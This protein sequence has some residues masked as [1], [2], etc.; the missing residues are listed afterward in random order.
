MPPRAA[1]VAYMSSYFRDPALAL[2]TVTVALLG[3]L[4]VTA[5]V[6]A[7]PVTAVVHA[8]HGGATDV[9]AWRALSGDVLRATASDL[10]AVGT[11][12]HTIASAAADARQGT[13]LGSAW[14]GAMSAAAA[15]RDAGVAGDA[16][17]SVRADVLRTGGMLAAVVSGGASRPYRAGRGIDVPDP[18]TLAP[19]TRRD[20]V[21]PSPPAFPARPALPAARPISPPSL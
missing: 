14:M 17:A 16:P 3:A 9:Q 10:V 4:T 7:A 8:A 18:R 15:L 12:L 5:A 21:R 6:T 20:P 2:A 13:E 19:A 1:T 11:E